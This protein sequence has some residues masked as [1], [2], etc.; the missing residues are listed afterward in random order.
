MLNDSSVLGRSGGSD[1]T[2]HMADAGS[3]RKEDAIIG[4]MEDGCEGVF[5]RMGDAG[6]ERMGD[7]SEIFLRD[8]RTS[9]ELSGEAEDGFLGRCS[10]VVDIPCVRDWVCC[11]NDSEWGETVKRTSSSGVEDE[12]TWATEFEGESE[13]SYLCSNCGCGFPQFF[14]MQT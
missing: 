1:G 7:E 3:L 6:S 4:R 12:D 9:D 5:L 13:R 2:L 8:S 14:I 10:G 11:K